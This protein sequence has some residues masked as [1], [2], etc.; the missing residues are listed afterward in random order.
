MT[1]YIAHPLRIKLD[2]LHSLMQ[3]LEAAG[4]ELPMGDW[5]EVYDVIEEARD[6]IAPDP[7]KETDL[8]AIRGERTPEMDERL[9]EC[10]LSL[11]HLTRCDSDGYC[12]FCGFQDPYPY[13]PTHR[14]KDDG[15][16]VMVV[17]K[18]GTE[19][20]LMNE[21]GDEWPEPDLNDWQPIAHLCGGCDRRIMWNANLH[22][23]ETIDNDGWCE[24]TAFRP[25]HVG[26]RR[27]W[28][29]GVLS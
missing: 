16:D 14:S 23:W 21:N 4:V 28:S 8:D 29:V 5:T 1:D 24:G 22:E 10:I 19:Y 6:E 27:H 3:E 2:W 12:E 26:D 18:D 15:S 17:R 7:F 13:R 25:P 11:A 20:V 9:R